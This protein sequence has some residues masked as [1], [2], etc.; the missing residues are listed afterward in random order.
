MANRDRLSDLPDYL[1]RR[2]LH[3]APA[4]E[5]ASTTALSRRWR[6]PLWRSSG[7]VNLETRVE[8]YEYRDRYGGYLEEDKA[9]FFS[10]RDA[11][12]SAA[13]VIDVVPTLTVVRLESVLIKVTDDA[14]SQCDAARDWGYDGV[15][16]Y[17]Q[18]ARCRLRC[19]AATVLT[20]EGCKW[21]EDENLRRRRHHGYYDDDKST[22]LI[23]VEID[24]PR[25]RRF[26]YMGLLRPFTFSPQPPELEQMDLHF[27]PG[28]KRNM[29]PCG[30][31]E[32]FWRFV[33]SFTST[34]KMNLRLNH[35]QDVAVLNEAR[36][37]ELLPAFRRL[38]CLELEGVRRG[39]G[40]TAAAA[41]ANLLRCSNALHDLRINL[42]T[43]HEDAY[44]QER[45]ITE[46]LEWKFRHD[47]DKSMDRF[48]RCD[49]SFSLEG[50]EETI[51]V[52]YDD[53]PEIPGL[54][55]RSF[56]CL[57]SSLR[58]V[59]LRFWPEKSNCLGIKLIKFFAENAMILEEMHIDA[60][61]GKL[62]E[63]VNHTI[64]TWINHSSKSR[65]L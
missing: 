22:P 31:L 11:F 18:D 64:E 15:P 21:E 43:E 58:R 51:S 48:D 36:R 28:K 8:D 13:K 47:R 40:K 39:R 32:T 6:T 9:L 44:K 49:D 34:K 25:L 61:N 41:I 62:C 38:E 24:S 19:P 60:G 5:A 35:L 16:D 26:R 23:A 20:L 33:G 59:A 1:L 37:V 2:V 46:F 29:D 50:D 56:E 14:T 17:K 65:N 54:S 10:R 57:Q 4:K 12:L 52:A 27:F 3:F 55:R 42:T 7:A 45:Y 53:V 30:N 63:H